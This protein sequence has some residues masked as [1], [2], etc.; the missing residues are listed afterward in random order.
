[1]STVPEGPM[2][3]DDRTEKRYNSYCNYTSS[4]G[5]WGCNSWGNNTDTYNAS[6]KKITSMKVNNQI[7]TLFALPTNK[8]TS[9]DYLNTNYYQSLTQEAKGLIIPHMFAIGFIPYSQSSTLKDDINYEQQYFWRGNIGLP[10]IT[11]YI[12]ASTD[13]GCTNVAS[14]LG[15][16][17]NP[18]ENTCYNNNFFYQMF[19][20]YSW[21]SMTYYPAYNDSE[22]RPTDVYGVIGYDGYGERGEVTRAGVYQDY[23]YI[24]PTIYLQSDIQIVD[25]KGSSSNPYIIS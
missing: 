1:M 22:H 13:S 11:D 16:D 20:N 9:N 6:G 5:Y 24:I 14:G 19:R 8:A 4:N 2:A 3:Y 25:G 15:A 17:Y 12:K 10:N 18:N 23:Y 21:Y 7:S